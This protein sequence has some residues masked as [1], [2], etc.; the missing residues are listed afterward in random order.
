ML[1]DDD[2]A[3]VSIVHLDDAVEVVSSGEVVVASGEVSHH[4]P[5][6]RQEPP[7]V[8]VMGEEGEADGAVRLAVR[9]LDERSSLPMCTQ[10]DADTVVAACALCVARWAA[11]VTMES[12]TR[13]LTS[14]LVDAPTPADDFCFPVVLHTTGAKQRC[15]LWLFFLFRLTRSRRFAMCG[16]SLLERQFQRWRRGRRSHFAIESDAFRD[17][18]LRHMLTRTCLRYQHGGAVSPADLWRT[19]HGRMNDSSMN[20]AMQAMISSTSASRSVGFA[21]LTFFFSML[22]KLNKRQGDRLEAANRM[23]GW[24]VGAE[25]ASA[26]AA[27]PLPLLT[28]VICHESA[29]DHWTLCVARYLP[30]ASGVSHQLV[31]YYADSLRERRLDGVSRRPSA[32]RTVELF[33]RGRLAAANGHPPRQV[34]SRIH[35]CEG[36]PQQHNDIDCGVYV[37]GFAARF[38]E[39]AERYVGSAWTPDEAALDTDPFLPSWDDWPEPD[40]LRGDVFNIVLQLRS[41]AKPPPVVHLT[42]A[43]RPSTKRPREMPPDRSPDHQ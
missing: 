12:L 33:L 28:C 6:T 7:D 17:L 24:K 5:P 18:V 29:R 10:G 1:Q 43:S 32:A 21:P 30:T 23:F 36:I 20:A 8:V 34:S 22:R 13:G 14:P 2:G 31:V 3:S 25:P 42:S 15:R 11:P 4:P 27:H 39:R 35:V 40:K 38:L 37:I 9:R 16:S 19:L 26:T 41:V